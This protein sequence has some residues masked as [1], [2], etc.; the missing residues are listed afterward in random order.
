M[1]YVL[2]IYTNEAVE[3]AMPEARRAVYMQEFIAFTRGLQATG[4]F[5]A[6]EVLQPVATA[7]TVRI[8]G[9]QVAYAE[10]PFAETEQQLGAFYVIEAR[11]LDEACAI[12][13]RVPSAVLGSVEVRPA[14]D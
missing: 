7:T 9:G 13:T 10:G 2:L 14:A 6:G 8:R 11:D 4:H 12:A 5:V 3:A 1:R